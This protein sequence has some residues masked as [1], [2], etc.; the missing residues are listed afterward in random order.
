M[1]IKNIVIDFNLIRA[2]FVMMNTSRL[3]LMRGGKMRGYFP[4]LNVSIALA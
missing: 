1:I 4:A 2:I 3:A